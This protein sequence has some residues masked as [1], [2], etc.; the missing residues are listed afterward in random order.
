[1][2]FAENQGVRIH[3]EVEGNGP[4]VVLM[5][6][7]SSDF[8]SWYEY[9]Y[10]KGLSGDYELILIDARGHGASDKPHTPEAYEMNRMVADVVSVL[11]D[12][13]VSKAGYMGYSMG[14]RI[15]FRIPLYAPN[16]FNSLILGGAVY[17]LQGD[18]DAKDEILAQLYLALEAAR[19]ESPDNP[20]AAYLA[21]LEKARGQTVSPTTRAVF[22]SNDAVALQAANLAARRSVNP[23]AE[24]AMPRFT[25][26]CLIFVGEADPRYLVAKECARRIAKSSFVSFPGLDHTL[27][28]ARSD[29]VL[30]HVRRFLVSNTS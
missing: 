24:D 12:H 25:M 18:E 1:M 14:G 6:G 7:F 10:V 13:G 29:L 27:T 8:R 22:L 28:F 4:P 26:P 3:Y 5:H 2:P 9:G 23:S 30:P 21:R 19:E 17:P 20:M 11:D 16:R 15:G